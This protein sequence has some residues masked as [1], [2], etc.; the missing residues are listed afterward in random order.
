[1]STT[2]LGWPKATAVVLLNLG[3][4][5]APT[6]SAVR[7][8]LREFLMDGRVIDLP[9]LSR[10]LLVNA[11]IA[12]FRS[13]KSAE[14][15]RTVWRDDGSPLLVHSKALVAEVEQ[16]LPGRR[17]HLAMRY[18][19]PSIGSVVQ[20]LAKEHVTEVVLLPLFPQYSSAAWGSAVE[21]FQEALA[22]LT[23]VP[24]LSIVPPFFL[25]DGFL[26]AHAGLMKERLA[27]HPVEH[28]VFSYHGLP[29]SQARAACS[30][31]CP[32]D[33][34]GTCCQ[35][36]TP[37]N[38][39]CYRAQCL[40]TT[41]QLAARAGVTTHSTVFQSRLGRADWLGPQLDSTLVELAKSGVKRVAVTCPAFVADCL[42]TLEEVGQ[43]SREKFLSSGGTHFELV[44]S[45]NADPRWAKAVAA[46]VRRSP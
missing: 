27:A 7:R 35:T 11:I 10:W 36:L 39:A 31:E 19:N 38:R 37:K 33:R 4:P 13:P 30:G 6:T 22:K 40:E 23:V 17:V 9:F 21:A 42:E 15:Y 43:V 16:A 46:L 8:Y 32:V 14:K 2:A 26:D 45:L 5:D 28:V 44:P 41:R 18:G 3:T 12:P 24:A 25:D 20:A 34:P 1:M 29:M